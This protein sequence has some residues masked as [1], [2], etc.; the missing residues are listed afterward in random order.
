[1]TKFTEEFHTKGTEIRMS[2]AERLR[3][4]AALREKMRAQPVKSPFFIPSPFAVRFAAV[5]ALV[6]VVGSGTAFAA[7]GSLPGDAL[8]PM[9]VS[10]VEPA[11]GAL[12][13]SDAAKAEWNEKVATTRLAEAQTLADEGRLTPEASTE[14]AANFS[15]HA[16]AVSAA[17]RRISATDPGAASDIDATFSS[18]VAA[19]GAAILAAGKKNANADSAQVSG[20]LVV[21]IATDEDTDVHGAASEAAPVAHTMMAMKSA[22]GSADAAALSVQTHAALASATSTLAS[23]NLEKG[24]LTAAK[25]RLANIQNRIVKADAELAIGSSSEAVDDYNR[26]LREIAALTQSV[27]AG[28]GT[29]DTDSSSE[30]TQLVPSL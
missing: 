7:E 28:A 11:V 21:A 5:F 19:H 3:V 10:V 17:T 27:N 25:V 18:A 23:L 12:Q 22:G 26:A 2:D 24:A 9:K 29:S 6:L 15:A 20:S 16:S 14:L 1:M 8:Y 13:F 4:H 30:D